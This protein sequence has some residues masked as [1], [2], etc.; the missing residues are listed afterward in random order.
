MTLWQWFDRGLSMPSGEGRGQ[1]FVEWWGLHQARRH[2][3][4]SAP[5]DVRIH[6]ESRINP[7]GGELTLGHRCSVAPG[8]VLQGNIR[9]GDDCS[10][11]A[12]SVLVGYGSAAEGTGLIHI[13]DRVRIAPHVMIIAANHRFAPGRPIHGQGLESAPVVIED[14]VWL[15]GRVSVMAGVT[16][17]RGS[18][19]G[20]GSVVT[21]DIPADSVAVG[22][23]A[24]VMRSRSDVGPLA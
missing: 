20:A 22:V 15:A 10:V 6:P 3:R 9:L 19:I 11:Q 1:R 4:F 16:I 12:Y 7:R 14:D 5:D 21:H 8:A 23:P 18:V 2:R 17:G 13:G 24:R